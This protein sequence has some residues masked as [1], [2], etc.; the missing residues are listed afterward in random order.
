MNTPNSKVNV[1]QL[2]LQTLYLRFRSFLVP[3][4]I[5]AACLFAAFIVVIPQ[6]QAFLAMRDEIAVNATKLQTLKDNLSTI[7]SMNNAELDTLLQTATKALP[8]E[9]DFSSILSA[10]NNA[11]AAAGVTL[12]NYNFQIGDIAGGEG[13]AKGGQLPLQLSLNIHGTIDESQRFVTQIKTQLPIS[14]VTSITA[15][16]DETVTL[17]LL[18][19]YAPL[20]K[21]VFNDDVAYPVLNTADKT[22]LKTLGKGIISTSETPIVLPTISLPP[23]PSGATPTPLL[24]PTVSPTIATSSAQ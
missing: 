7:T 8:A 12:G 15:N 18:F 20:P 11:A 3:A 14:D 22:L 21:I 17:I 9:K 24:S 16:A 6:L 2:V 5:I 19:Y 1:D 23:L 13:K 10:I 4:G